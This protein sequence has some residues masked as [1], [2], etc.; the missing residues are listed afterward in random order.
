MEDK[1]YLV[2]S[3]INKQGFTY[4]LYRLGNKMTSKIGLY[5]NGQ[6]YK[7]FDHIK[8]ARKEGQS[9]NS[10]SNFMKFANNI[11]NDPDKKKFIMGL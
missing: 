3:R 6:F 8:D 5:I 11:L 1:K 7:Q 10:N 4:T 2:D 9:Y